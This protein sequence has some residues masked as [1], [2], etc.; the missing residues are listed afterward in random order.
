V[1]AQYGPVAEDIYNAALEE[2]HAA[3][4]T[5][6]NDQGRPLLAALVK[7]TNAYHAY[8]ETDAQQLMRESA[9]RYTRKIVLLIGI[10]VAALAAAVV[11]AVLIYRRWGMA[12]R[13]ENIRGIHCREREFTKACCAGEWR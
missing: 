6:M 10:C 4:I 3:A 2:R 13:P 11:A 5:I 7:A 9:E 1:A 8:T 12:P